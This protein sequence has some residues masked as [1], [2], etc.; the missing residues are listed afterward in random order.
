MSLKHSETFE[1][2]VRETLSTLLREYL[3]CSTVFSPYFSCLP[4]VLT[5]LY[6]NESGVYGVDLSEASALHRSSTFHSPIHALV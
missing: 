3:H 6:P 4:Q 1:Q 2:V 5:L